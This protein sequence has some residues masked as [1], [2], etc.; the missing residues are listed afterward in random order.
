MPPLPIIP[1]AYLIAQHFTRTD[2]LHDYVNVMT[3]QD[4]TPPHTPLQIAEKFALAFG[5][6]LFSVMDVGVTFGETEVTPLD[7]TSAVETFETAQFG[8]HGGHTTGGAYPVSGSQLITWQT[9]IRGRQNRGR[10]YLVGVT[11]DMVVTP[12]ERALTNAQLAVLQLAGTGFLADLIAGAH[13]ELHLMVLSRR[14]A[15]ATEAL[16]A[17]AN[18]GVC[19]QRRRFEVVA[20]R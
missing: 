2:E 6:S 15:H 9:G 16:T 19:S 5:A 14:G 3:V 20:H 1:Q 11:D 18:L 8:S 17:R 10:T 4:H 12:A 7:G 13:P